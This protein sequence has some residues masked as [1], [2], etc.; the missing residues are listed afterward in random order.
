[1]EH[2][3]KVCVLF[4]KRKKPKDTKINNIIDYYVVVVVFVRKFYLKTR[5]T[6]IKKR[7]EKNTRE[8]LQSVR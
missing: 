3:N 2:N 7:E 4:G 8:R 5:D 1:M 6:T